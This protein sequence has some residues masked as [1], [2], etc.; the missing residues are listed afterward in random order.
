[1]QPHIKWLQAVGAERGVL[2]RSPTQ[3]AETS[4]KFLSKEHKNGLSTASS[5]AYYSSSCAW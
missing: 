4:A 5:Y 3:S 1:M 2:F